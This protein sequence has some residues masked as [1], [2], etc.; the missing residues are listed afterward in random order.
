MNRQQIRKIERNIESICAQVECYTGGDAIVDGY[1]DRGVL[2][3]N[4]RDGNH[5]DLVAIQRDFRSTTW[6]SGKSIFIDFTHEAP[7]AAPP[8]ITR[9][10]YSGYTAQSDDA[11]SED[12]SYVHQ[13]GRV[14][15][16]ED[17]KGRW[18]EIWKK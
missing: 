11:P 7:A 16:G 2:Q 15:M 9:R 6:Q 4:L 18:W 13:P 10:Q 12:Y 3:M 17:D 5:A 8:V 14:A 1:I